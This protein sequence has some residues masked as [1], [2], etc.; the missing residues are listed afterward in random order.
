MAQLLLGFLFVFLGFLP[1]SAQ[2]C[3]R[4]D[5][6]DKKQQK[7]LMCFIR[8]CKSKGFLTPDSGYIYL[9][10]WTDLQGQTNWQMA[11]LKKWRNY[12]PIAP[13]HGHCID[14]LAPTGWTKVDNR[15][16]LRYNADHRDTL[17]KAESDCLQ[18]ILAPHVTIVP[19]PGSTF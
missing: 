4:L 8:E 19:P 5:I 7:V 1:V 10:E 9:S 11:A 17:T 13:F 6:Q 3:E 14:C 15:L 12:N 16:V 2:P 18:K